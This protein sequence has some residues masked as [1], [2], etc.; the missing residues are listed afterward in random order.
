MG[1]QDLNLRPPGPQ[2]GAPG[3]FSV[4]Y[5]LDL[6]GF[7]LLSLC[8]FRSICSRFVPRRRA[9]GGEAGAVLL[10][11]RGCGTRSGG[12]PPLLAG[13]G[14]GGSSLVVATV[15]SMSTGTPLP[16]LPLALSVAQADADRLRLLGRARWLTQLALGWHVCEAAIAIAA[17]AVAGSVA[18][19]GFGA[20][21]LIEAG[22]GLVVLWLVTGER[23][24]SPR[25][26]RRAQLLIAVSFVL[27]AAYVAVEAAH[28]LIG[29]HHPAT[30]WVGVGLSAVTL[31]AMPPL[32]AAKRRVGTALGSS[33]TVSES[34][35]TMLCA[36]LSVA[37]LIGLLANAVAGWWWADPLVALVIAA[38]AVREAREGW[39]GKSCS[40]C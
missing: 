8:Q 15:L 19:V 31:V 27:L 11:R 20:D 7:L 29:G 32:A 37:L 33:A 2:P 18:L 26:E 9:S 22:A 16:T 24:G 35:Q 34:R 10:A 1:R 39:Q 21:S 28:D 13:Q 40:C 23:L 38:V 25:A 12:A 3:V 36:Y 4:S 17:G 30:S 6:Q 5:P 14:F